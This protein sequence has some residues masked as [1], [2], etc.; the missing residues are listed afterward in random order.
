MNYSNFNQHTWASFKVFTIPRFAFII[1]VVYIIILILLIGR[2]ILGGFYIIN[3]AFKTFC[4]GGLQKWLVGDKVKEK[5][6]TMEEKS[7]S[8]FLKDVV[9][10]NM[11]FILIIIAI[12]SL[13]LTPTAISSIVG[14]ITDFYDNI[15]KQAQ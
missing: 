14:G 9:L 11:I 7:I 5:V 3:P 4:D 2:T 1:Q 12:R 13:L 15:I 6:E 10:H 8:I